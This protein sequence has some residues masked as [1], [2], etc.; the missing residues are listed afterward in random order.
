[1][2]KV[3]LQLYLQ[4]KFTTLNI[5]LGI[6]DK[7][8]HKVIPSKKDYTLATTFLLSFIRISNVRIACVGGSALFWNHI[9]PI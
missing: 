4:Q 3:F 5:L 9:N 8:K 2:L 1:M 7:T 6:W